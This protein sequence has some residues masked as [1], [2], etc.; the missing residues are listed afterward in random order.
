VFE[1]LLGQHNWSR[2][3]QWIASDQH[4]FFGGHLAKAI[5]AKSVPNT[6]R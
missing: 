6:A 3:N 4:H 5:A 1:A 2:Y